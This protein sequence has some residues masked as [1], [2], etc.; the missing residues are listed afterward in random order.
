M[1]LLLAAAGLGRL[2]VGSGRLG[3]VA[4]ASLEVLHALLN[5]LAC[6]SRIVSIGKFWC[7]LVTDV[8]LTVVALGDPVLN[9]TTLS[10][11]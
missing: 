1:L 6:G 4:G 3:S 8:E 2:L 5:L 7:A 10:K 11:V 9:A